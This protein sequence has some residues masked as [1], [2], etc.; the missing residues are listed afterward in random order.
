MTVGE[1]STE[2]NV[3]FKIQGDS[4]QWTEWFFNDDFG[5]DYQTT[6]WEV[7]LTDVGTA[8]QILI[9]MQ[10]TDGFDITE[11]EVDGDAYTLS[12]TDDASLDYP[13]GI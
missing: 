12:G 1:S 3:F 7:S 4:N 5:T 13:Y 2:E 6:T 10:N 11:I 9:L 8:K